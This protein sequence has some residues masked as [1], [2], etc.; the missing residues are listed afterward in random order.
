MCL[1]IL[2]KM[3]VFQINTVYNVG[4]TG[5]IAAQLK[6]EI[7]N[8]DGECVV[9]YGRGR[10]DEINTYRVGTNIDL[11]SHV[12]MTRVTDKAGFYSKKSTQELII[13]IKEF[14][15]EIIHLHNLHGYFLHLG[16]LFEFL[17]DYG[18]PVVWTLHDCW[19]FTGHCAHYAS[20]HCDKWKSHC[21]QCARKKEYPA[22]YW[23][24]NSWKNYEK[25]RE[26]FLGIR[27][28]VIVTPSEWLAREVKKSF[29]GEYIV[30]VIRNGIYTKVF[31][32][33]KSKIREKR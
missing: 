27:N 31:V 11:Y 26:L 29:L 33:C 19:A 5:R 7:E 13:R 2:F 17:K 8:I 14:E 22:S 32:P 4:S 15:P 3:K 10:S 6:H 12:L 18:K 1:N 23:L 30:K 25:K 24:D 9:A 21:F 16:I 28:M 20:I